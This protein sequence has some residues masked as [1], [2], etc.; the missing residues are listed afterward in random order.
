MRNGDFSALLPS[1]IQ[2]YDTQ[3]NFAPYVGN[4]NV[5]IVNP[6]ATYLFAHPELY[7]LPNH[8][9]TDGL[10]QANYQGSQSSFTSTNQE[11]FKVDFTPGYAN[12][13]NG[14]YSQGKGGDFTSSIIPITFPA[15]STYPTK[16]AGAS[17]VHTFSP[18]IINQFRLGFT[19][20]R[21]NNGVPSDPS[22]AFGT[23]GDQKV[24]ITLPFPQ[25]F[26]GFTGQQMNSNGLGQV[27]YIG[28]QANQQ[29]FTDNTFNY[30][31]N[32]IWQHGRHS[33]SVGVQAT[34]YQQNYL[35]T[36]NVGFLG[37]FGYTGQYTGLATGGGYGPADFVL[38]R[39]QNVSLADPQSNVGNETF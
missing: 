21:W 20:V 6:V 33:I 37:Q 16:I 10:L 11:D 17:W 4:L 29:V 9:P 39:I 22:G 28:T 15:H 34:R 38:G 19:R 18:S 14:F 26:A 24:G 1:G 12:Q 31:D 3:N 8:A 25:T 23:N 5:P 32:L 7:P 27:S 36:G 30:Y 35:S 13:I 2:L